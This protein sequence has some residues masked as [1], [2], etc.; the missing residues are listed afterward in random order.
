MER[1]SSWNDY[2]LTGIVRI[3]EQHKE[4]VKRADSLMDA[5]RCGAGADELLIMLNFLDQ[6]VKFHFDAEVEFMEEV[7]H[8][9]MEKHKAE[10]EWFKTTLRGFTKTLSEGGD[11]DIVATDV[12]N[13]IFDWLVNHIGTIDKELGH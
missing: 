13:E 10:H 1:S 8:P 5:I 2:L 6:Y 9:S 12:K 3:D 4:L 7:N 11:P